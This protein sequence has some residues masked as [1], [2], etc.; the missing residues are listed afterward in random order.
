MAVGSR[1]D[2]RNFGQALL[3]IIIVFVLLVLAAAICIN[4]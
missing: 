1:K 3:T 4:C 2:Y